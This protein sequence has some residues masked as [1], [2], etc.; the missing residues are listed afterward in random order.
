[1]WALSILAEEGFEYDSS[2]FPVQHDIYGIPKASRRPY[3]A[4][5]PGGP[6][7]E[8]PLT[9]FRLL[10]STNL[11]VGGGGYL[12]ILPFWYTRS[13]IA[14]AQAQS[15]PLIAYIHP[16]ELDPNQPRISAG[17]KSRLRHYTNLRHTQAKLRKLIGM[18]NFT[19]FEAVT[20]ETANHILS[21]G[22]DLDKTVASSAAGV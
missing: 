11:P 16:W 3:R 4:D 8:F 10:G 1:L 12:R 9:T 21:L 17:F 18:G 13:G 7:M 14:L 2:I 19:S 22:A 15:I 5:T 20:S 6:I